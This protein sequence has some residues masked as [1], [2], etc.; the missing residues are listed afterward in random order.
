MLWWGRIT[1][2]EERRKEHGQ[3]GSWIS[4]ATE[5]VLFTLD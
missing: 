5:F 1:R 2:R 4:K 3:A